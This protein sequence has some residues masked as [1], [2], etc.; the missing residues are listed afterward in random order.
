MTGGGISMTSTIVRRLLVVGAILALPARGY[1]QEATMSGTI[2]DSTGGV[3]PGVTV[4]A[5]HE[6]SGNTFE[7]VTAERGT[8]RIAA[9]AGGYP[10]A[11]A[12]PAVLAGPRHGV[13]LLRGQLGGRE[14]Q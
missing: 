13:G 10:G 7:A 14:L 3:L 1:G 2:T 5:L 8:Y 12:L 6:A 4:T 9:R 11:A